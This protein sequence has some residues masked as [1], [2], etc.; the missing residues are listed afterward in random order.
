MP[1]L[2]SHIS[3]SLAHHVASVGFRFGSL[4]GAVSHVFANYKLLEITQECLGFFSIVVLG[5]RVQHKVA[6]EVHVHMTIYL[7]AL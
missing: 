1:F 2:V 7:S 3:F 4:K 5:V 6:A